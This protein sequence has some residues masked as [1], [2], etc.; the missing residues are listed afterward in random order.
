MSAIQK[1]VG[2]WPPL[3]FS[4]FLG[5]VITMLLA[6]KAVQIIKISEAGPA[7]NPKTKLWGGLGRNGSRGFRSP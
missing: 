7:P 3:L 4:T 5:N 2:L 6:N 1:V